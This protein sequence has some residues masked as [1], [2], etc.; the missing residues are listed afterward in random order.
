M[1]YVV[2]DKFKEE[3]NQVNKNNVSSY[4]VIVAHE[5][6]QHSFKTATYLNETGNL[7]QYITTVYDKP[8][9]F[10]RYLK[11]LLR[12]QSKQ[13]CASRHCD[14]LPD[15]IITQYCEMSGLFLLFITRIP[16]INRIFP[17]YYN[18]LHD[19]FGR[20]VADYAIQHNTDA[21]IMYDTNS[22]TC[23]KCLK[24]RAPQIKRILDVT[25]GN[26]LYAQLTYNK[27]VSQ[28]SDSRILDEI[29][30]DK[31]SNYKERIK[32]EL[33]LADYYFVGSE[34]VAESLRYSGVSDNKIC[35]IP[36]GV[37]V[38]AFRD[39]GKHEINSCLRLIFVGSVS[40]RKG[41]HHL[42]SVVSEYT[43]AE[44][45]LKIVGSYSSETEYYKN[46]SDRD[47]IHFVGFVNHDKLAELYQ[48][49]DIFVLPSLSEG[50]AQ[51]SLEAMGCGL[52]IICTTNSGCNDV[53]T[54][55]E[56]GFVIKPS[57]RE[58]LKSRIDWFI[59]N[60]DKIKSM[61]SKCIEI[62][63]KYTWEAYGKKLNKEIKD[64]LND[65]R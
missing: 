15:T 52:P 41:I 47:N 29:R 49:A 57:D 16:F 65:R 26:R 6:K 2:N 58:A 7:Q 24:N 40:Y 27:D 60:K 30:V 53:I 14:S 19:R 42:L 9:S 50:F 62:A 34:Y 54:D 1:E 55:F 17:G 11:R 13:K 63:K 59:S 45:S 12:G 39:K 5:G 43:K 64:I 22:N 10:T 36:Y 23:F 32:E 51:V 46:Y 25:I 56:T 61:G 38:K 4:R 31:I 18:W 21:V 28:F 33:C 3:N 37:N 48:E 20:H 8:G 44:V 35:I